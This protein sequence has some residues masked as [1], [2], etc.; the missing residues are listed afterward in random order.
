M[1]ASIAQMHTPAH[2]H[3]RPLSRPPTNCS[4]PAQ[5]PSH[6]PSRMHPERTRTLS[7]QRGVLDI[8]TYSIVRGEARWWRW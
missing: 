5:R 6:P 2:Y 4:R 8:H 7:A 1:C 3:A